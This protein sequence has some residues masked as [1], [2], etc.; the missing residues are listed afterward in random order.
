MEEAGNILPQR[1]PI[2]KGLCFKH[3]RNDCGLV[4]VAMEGQNKGRGVDMGVYMRVND[5]GIQAKA[6]AGLGKQ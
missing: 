2:L 1:T 4:T 6:G 5:E 3:G